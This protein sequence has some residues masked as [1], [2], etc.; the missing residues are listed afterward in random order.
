MLD[1]TPPPRYN[2]SMKESAYERDA[3]EIYL[4]RKEIEQLENQ[5]EQLCEEIKRLQEVIAESRRGGDRV[6]PRTLC[7]FD[8][9][10]PQGITCSFRYTGT[11]P[12][13]G[14]RRCYTCG[15]LE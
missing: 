1:T 13:T 4:L 12:G 15:E 9:S 14:L 11:D 5:R 2:E 3:V 10:Q 7:L 8:P 6:C